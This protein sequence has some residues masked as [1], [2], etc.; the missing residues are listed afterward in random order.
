MSLTKTLPASSNYFTLGQFHR[1][2]L[3]KKNIVPLAVWGFTCL[4]RFELH[5]AKYLLNKQEQKNIL[6]M[7][8][9]YEWYNNYYI[10]NVYIYYCL[11]LIYTVNW[12]DLHEVQSKETSPL[13]GIKKL[14][15]TDPLLEGTKACYEVSKYGNIR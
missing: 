1:T 3:L 2:S 6:W 14:A 8:W 15:M 12:H 4:W 9:P 5:R 13:M 10:S 7:R 11:I